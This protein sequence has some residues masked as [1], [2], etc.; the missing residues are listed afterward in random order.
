MKILVLRWILFD[1]MRIVIVYFS[2]IH[3][4]YKLKPKHFRKMVKFRTNVRT[5]NFLDK[6][7]KRKKFKSWRSGLV[8]W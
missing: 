5:K 8:T 7:E 6:L 2:Y 4:I 1:F 3:Y